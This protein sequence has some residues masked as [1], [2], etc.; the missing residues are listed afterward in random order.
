M[1]DLVFDLENSPSS[2]SSS[3]S[4]RLE[5]H[6]VVM[7]SYEFKNKAKN[8]CSNWKRL[9]HK[10]D[11]LEN[12]WEDFKIEEYPTEKAIVHNYNPLTKLW[13]KSE[14]SVKM[15]W[16]KAPFASGAMRDCFRL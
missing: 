11:K 16:P 5:F 3:K 12:P 15:E 6:E 8:K 2:K 9:T 14:C 4:E 10:I 1:D 7:L 13:G